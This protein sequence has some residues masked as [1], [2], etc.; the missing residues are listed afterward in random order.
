M[1]RIERGVNRC[2]VTAQFAA[3]MIDSPQMKLTPTIAIPSLLMLLATRT[4][5]QSKPVFEENFESGK[6]DPAVWDQRVTGTATR[7]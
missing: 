5:A 3:K 4:P 6:L 1:P 7:R 2:C